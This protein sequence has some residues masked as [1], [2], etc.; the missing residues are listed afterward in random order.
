MKATRKTI[1]L[2]AAAL[3]GLGA[4]AWILLAWAG[5]PPHGAAG[6]G[7]GGEPGL[8][9][10]TRLHD[11]GSVQTGTSMTYSFA[12]ENTG[13]SPVRLWMERLGCNCLSVDC[14]DSVG[15]G[16]VVHVTVTVETRNREGAFATLLSVGTSD[17]ALPSVDLEVR[18][19]VHPTIDVD[20]PHLSF[21]DA[22]RGSVLER[23]V[24][25]R[26]RLRDEE[27][28]APPLALEPSFPALTCRLAESRVTVDPTTR[29]RRAVYRFHARLDTA[30][31]PA[32]VEG[33][34]RGELRV[35]PPGTSETPAKEVPVEVSFRH[36]PGLSG[37]TSVAVQRKTGAKVRVR[38][39]SIQRTPFDIEKIT[40]A[41]PGVSARAET[42]G[43]AVAH[44]VAVSAAP[45]GGADEVEKGVL[46]IHSPQYPSQ[47]YRLQVV[48]LP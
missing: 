17:P 3:V 13:Q 39:W 34:Y 2:L 47:P 38:L 6:A 19:Y 33:P 40:V 21:A 43:Q 44:L 30:A 29:L 18:F 24:A 4:A 16:S 10:P 12:V 7:A 42:S 1:F 9:F 8:L 14:P 36:H 28:E 26:L 15:P 23:D 25:V 46:E 48:V 31:L 22:A 11:F 35:R 37:Q 20:P 41:A 27:A 5:V 45:G 32:D